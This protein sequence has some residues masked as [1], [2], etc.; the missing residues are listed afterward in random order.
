MSKF[1]DGISER[2]ATFAISIIKA[3]KDL[4]RTA[5]GKHIYLQLFRSATSSGPNYEEACA[6]ESRADFIHKMQIT[7]KE[8]REACYWIRLISAGNFL[9]E[10]KP[11]LGFLL[12][13][14]KEL[15]NIIGKSV[16]TAKS[17]IK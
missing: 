9:T 1:S 15:S 6:G 17:K 8:L 5:S 10:S 13:E 16:V 7:L 4:C 2:L 14:S 11:L 3:E 12:K